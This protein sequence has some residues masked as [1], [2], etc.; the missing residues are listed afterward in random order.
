MAKVRAVLA[1]FF[2]VA[3]IAASANAQVAQIYTSSEGA[4]PGLYQVNF[5]T[6]KLTTLYPTTAKLDDMLVTPSGQIIYS[7]PSLGQVDM[8]TPST[9]VNTILATGVGDARDLIITPNGQNLM[10]AGHTDP[11][12]IY[13]Y[14][15]AS[16]KTTVFVPKTKG[17]SNMDGLAYDVYGNFYAV[18]NNNTIVQ[19]NPTTGAVIATIV[20]EPHSG[21]NG[22]D[23]LCYDSTTN[24][25]WATHDGKTS[26][27]GFG[28]MQIPV[29]P[30]GFVST[31]P[32]FTFH[33][34]NIGNTDGI[35]SDGK[36]NLYIGA[37]WTAEVYNIPTDTLVGSVVVKGSDGV[38]LVPGTY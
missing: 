14:N 21:V 20:M 27:L 28:L 5:S 37:I 33:P 12:S 4:K 24:S 30:S 2:L 35:K 16:G 26:P 8:Y 32:G 38:G 15:F 6:G 34:W 22:A 13:Q 17:I 25:L 23:G 19:L 11:A 9:G 1:S 7:I 3:A 36:G 18:E 10:M 29:Q 31:S